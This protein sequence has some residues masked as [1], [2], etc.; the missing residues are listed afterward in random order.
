MESKA[1]VTDIFLWYDLL[2]K[3]S[4]YSPRKAKF[5]FKIKNIPTHTHAYILSKKLKYEPKSPPQL[6]KNVPRLIF[7]AVFQFRIALVYPE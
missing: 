6:F 7:A 2:S 3:K 1:W 5:K 4:S